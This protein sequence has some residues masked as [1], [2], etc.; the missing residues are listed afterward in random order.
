M[1]ECPSRCFVIPAA[2][3]LVVVGKKRKALHVVAASIRSGC[4]AGVDY[5]AWPCNRAVVLLQHVHPTTMVAWCR[6]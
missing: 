1:V 3:N 6:G 5:E 4:M 2:S